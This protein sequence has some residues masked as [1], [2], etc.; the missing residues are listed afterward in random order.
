MAL[1]QTCGRP[2]DQFALRVVI[3]SPS[4]TSLIRPNFSGTWNVLLMVGCHVMPYG[5]VGGPPL[6]KKLMRSVLPGPAGRVSIL[7][8]GIFIAAYQICFCESIFARTSKP[9]FHVQ[10]SS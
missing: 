6:R 7:L 1:P 10:P 3:C 8:Y 9:E 4:S 2:V 5:C